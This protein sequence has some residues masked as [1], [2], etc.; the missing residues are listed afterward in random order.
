MTQWHQGSQCLQRLHSLG[1]LLASGALATA[2]ILCDQVFPTSLVG[3]LS[4][5]WLH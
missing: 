2:G 4:S 3:A 1:I 5:S